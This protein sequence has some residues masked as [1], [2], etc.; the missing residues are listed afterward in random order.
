MKKSPNRMR[1]GSDSRWR[2]NKQE[3]V[4][5]DFASMPITRQMTGA[6]LL[7]VLPVVQA[8]GGVE[9]AAESRAIDSLVHAYHQENEVEPSGLT[10]DSEFLRR[11]YLD[12][13]GTI[14]ALEHVRRFLASKDPRKRSRLIADLVRSPGYASHF[15]NYWAALL[16]IPMRTQGMPNGVYAAWVHDA[17]SENMPYDE[18]VYQLLTAEGDSA[19][20]PATGY[21]L[22]DR[23]MRFD[24]VSATAQVFLGSQ[25]GCA[26]CHDHKFDK[27]TQQ[28][29]YR[30]AAYMGQVSSLRD[31]GEMRRVRREMVDA[32][33]QERRELQRYLNNMSTRIIDRP[34]RAL[35]YPDD[36]A[37]DNARPGAVV[38]PRVLFGEQPDIAAGESQREAFARWLTSPEN[39]NFTRV[40]VN[41]LWKKAMG[42]GLVEPVDDFNDYTKALQPELLNH[43]TALMK[44]LD[45]DMRTFMQILF[46]T[47]MYQVAAE[48][49]DV[50][51]RNY[52]LQAAP[53]R[54]MTAEQIWDSLITLTAGDANRIKSRMTADSSDMMMGMPDAVRPQKRDR[55][56]NELRR[57]SDVPP[58]TRISDTLNQFGRATRE[59]VDEGSTAPSIPQVLFLM[60]GDYLGRILGR[61]GVGLARNLS[62]YDDPADRI[63][64]IYLTILTREPSEQEFSRAMEHVHGYAARS[65][66]GYHDLAWALLNTR[67]FLFIR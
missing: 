27:W 55:R 14:P 26:Q 66:A 52:R 54:R 46:N 29:Y 4:S 18:L 19:E 48:G 20:N 43:L 56:R 15:F 33:P 58:G 22:R 51:A 47:R 63:R 41:R 37:Y 44:R 9:I 32:S 53:L 7:A 64:V 3:A 59:T 11:A 62:D 39:P 67:E 42:I 13:T 17:L 57:A 61:R 5:V 16:R 60:N 10:T 6:F 40:I 38:E 49:A 1:A 8:V 31:R 23:Q 2:Y 50:T 25:I 12:I 65:P 36:Y 35:R 28:D 34:R 24:T 45:Y 30:F 21:Y